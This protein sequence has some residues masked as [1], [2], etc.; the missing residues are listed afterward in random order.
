VIGCGGKPLELEDELELEE[1]LELEDE[2]LELVDELLALEDALLELEL[3]LELE[4]ELEL[5]DVPVAVTLSTCICPPTFNLTCNSSPAVFGALAS[6]RML[7]PGPTIP[8][9]SVN[10]PS[11]IE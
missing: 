2:L 5:T 4:E 8:A 9:K 1:E 3:E 11:L 10:G 7:C 6:R